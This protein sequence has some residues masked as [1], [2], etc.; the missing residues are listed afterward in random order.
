VVVHDTSY[1][2]KCVQAFCTQVQY[3][4]R[5]VKWIYWQTV[6]VVFLLAIRTYFT[7][8]TVIG[9]GVIPSSY[10]SI[11]LIILVISLLKT[12]WDRIARSGTMRGQNTNLGREILLCYDPLIRAILANINNSDA[13]LSSIDVNAYY[14]LVVI[15]LKLVYVNF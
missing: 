15:L 14:Y 4:G 1:V 12:L 8:T 10:R 11:I 7:L 5:F 6:S 9:N 3:L 13:S 2:L